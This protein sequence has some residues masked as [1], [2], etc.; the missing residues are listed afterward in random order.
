MSMKD[1]ALKY[2]EAFSNKNLDILSEI[3]AD[4]IV[5]EDWVETHRGKDSVI[6]ANRGL[7]ETI[8]IV[9]IKVLELFGCG[10]SKKIAGSVSCK[11]EIT[12]ADAEDNTTLLE[13]VDI[14]EFDE[15]GKISDI[16]AYL[17]NKA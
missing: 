7:F 9:T 11:I 5:L 16:K 6:E 15:D 8:E 10:C 4:D 14:L 17:G 13:V 12:L 2:F 1:R 3:Y